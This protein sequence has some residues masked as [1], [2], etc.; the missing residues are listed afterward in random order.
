MELRAASCART[1]LDALRDA[2]SGIHVSWTPFGVAPD[3]LEA[4]TVLTYDR[5]AERWTGAVTFPGP[6]RWRSNDPVGSGQ[7][8]EVGWDDLE[9]AQPSPHLPFTGQQIVLIDQETFAAERRWT[10]DTGGLG[11]LTDPE[12][13]VF[14]QPRDGG[15]WLVA[16]D[17]ATGAVEA[18][19]EV[20]PWPYTSVVPAPDG[21]AVAATW[22]IAGKSRE[23][24]LVGSDGRVTEITA[25]PDIELAMSWAP[26]AET[27][28]V[29]GETLRLLNDDGTVR[30]EQPLAQ[31]GTPSVQ[32]MPDGS[33]ALVH[34]STPTGM[35]V[36]WVDAATGTREVVFD[37]DDNVDLSGILG[38]AIAPNG[39][40]V[41]LTWRD[42]SPG[43]ALS[44]LPIGE[45]V[46]L[47]A[48]VLRNT[49]RARFGAGT[50][51]AHL[52]IGGLSWAPDSTA[53]AF[54][55]VNHSAVGPGRPFLGIRSGVYVLDIESREV[56]DVASSEQFYATYGREVVWSADGSMLFATRYPCTGC[57]P[58]TA[59]ID[60]IVAAGQDD[61]TSF[62]DAVYLRPVG[63]GNAHLLST[64]AGLIRTD[65]RDRGT[66]VYPGSTP[67][68]GGGSTRSSTH[69]AVLEGRGPG[70]A[71]LAARPDGTTTRPLGRSARGEWVLAAL[72]AETVIV[73]SDGRWARLSLAT[74]AVE[75]F[76]A[77]EPGLDPGQ[78]V[79]S[80]SGRLL[81]AATGEGYAILDAMNPAAAAVVPLRP[82]PDTSGEV[83]WSTD[84]RWIAFGDGYTIGVVD[85]E[86][87]EDHVFDLER[88]GVGLDQTE[89]G[90]NRLWG[91]VWSRE[92]DAVEFGAGERLW[93][94]EVESASATAIA[95]APQPGGFT[96][97][98]IL[99]RS[100]DGRSLVAAT[101]FGVFVLDEGA[102]EWRLISRAGA[103]YQGRGLA[104]APDGS[105]VAYGAMEVGLSRPL[106]IIIAPLDGGAYQFVA[107]FSQ[108]LGWMPDGEV[109][110][111]L[112]PAG[113]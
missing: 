35:R 47:D 106:G 70:T 28:I 4:E 96:Q 112:P 16:G 76:T 10:A 111:A 50:D 41:A 38:M 11:W 49:I 71:L 68:F 59:A 103:S 45:V 53:L 48:V 98:T 51:E 99:S 9:L 3:G 24:R 52:E 72:D 43:I 101:G 22:G 108:I 54:V 86:S 85:L 91:I 90:R 42:A 64:P 92:G 7:W 1:T 93:R 109:V 89:D 23:F 80:P 46:D 65:G 15:V 94:L 61:V 60:A 21:R 30:S 36:E 77:V 2:G 87:G 26:N 20:G 88:L 100:P 57:G 113:P 74:G 107:P 5:E 66:P 25:R 55:L 82:Y 6:G 95:D 29:A 104:W 17:V 33:R 105:A 69:V 13:I 62:E 14:L 44:V 40:Q 79:M 39:E 56:R 97:F 102:T 83:A 34:F 67:L 75:P 58:E 73:Q 19:V 18:L 12:R 27:L 8:F 78:L 31:Q 84:E 110:W 37:E 63:D 81:L 32:W